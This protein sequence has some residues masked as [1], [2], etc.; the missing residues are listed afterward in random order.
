MPS[1]ML[2]KHWIHFFCQP[3]GVCSPSA[4]SFDSR[5][6]FIES[7][8]LTLDSVSGAGDMQRIHYCLRRKLL[9]WRVKVGV[10][11]VCQ[12]SRWVNF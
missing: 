1:A 10:V 11:Q 2:L 9:C 4:A 3:V 8:P 5:S 12:V 6:L 7:V